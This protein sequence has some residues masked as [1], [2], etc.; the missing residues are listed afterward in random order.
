MDR[1]RNPLVG[2]TA[3]KG[4][5]SCRIRYQGP[6]ATADADRLMDQTE[7]QVRRAAGVYAFGAGPD[8]LPSVVL[9][10][11]HPDDRE[12]ESQ[13]TPFDPGDFVMAMSAEDQMAVRSQVLH[14]RITHGRSLAHLS[15][16]SS[17]CLSISGRG[18]PNVTQSAGAVIAVLFVCAL[19]VSGAVFLILELD[20]SFEG[21]L[22]VSGAPLRTALAQLGE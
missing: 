2:T 12:D 20:R 10:L 11:L 3:S 19:S 15:P 14:R 16:S 21:L 8:T 7:A 9:D 18:R 13:E 22:Q 17:C 1:G 5:V 6:A 4:G